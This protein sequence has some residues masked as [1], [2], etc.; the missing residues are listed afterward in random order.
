MKTLKLEIIRS[1]GL[2]VIKVLLEISMNSFML[3][4]LFVYPL[5]NR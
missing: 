2:V 4:I 5:R 1:G 3:L